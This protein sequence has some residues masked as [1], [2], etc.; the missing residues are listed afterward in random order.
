MAVGFRSPLPLGLSKPHN[1]DV[2]YRGLLAFWC[3]GATSITPTAAAGVHS[4]LAPWLGGAGVSQTGTTGYRAL[5]A[6]WLGGAGVPAFEPTAPLEQPPAVRNPPL[7]G[8]PQ[9]FYAHPFE[10]PDRYPEAS[11]RS[12]YRTRAAALHEAEQYGGGAV[13]AIW[14]GQ[15]LA[16]VDV[17]EYLPLVADRGMPNLNHLMLVVNELHFELL[18]IMKK[19]G[20]S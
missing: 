7:H 5:L 18:A 3:G 16:S 10:E 13:A 6:S 19:K 14:R 17:D 11:A 9:H 15:A 1:T 2:G 12:N 20:K 8:Y 4:L